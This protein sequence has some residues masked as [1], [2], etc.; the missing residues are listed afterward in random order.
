MLLDHYKSNICEVMFCSVRKIVSSLVRV[1]VFAKL[2]VSSPLI[3]RV[4]DEFTKFLHF[5][6]RTNFG[7][8]LDDII[9]N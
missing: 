1:I 5:W 8:M 4:L 3:Y 6:V 9:K 2:A 7:H